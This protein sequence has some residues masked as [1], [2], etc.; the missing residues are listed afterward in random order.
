M[1]DSLIEV[2]QNPEQHVLTRGQPKLGK[3]P[4][5]EAK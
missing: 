3:K 1:I 4:R 5:F 2:T